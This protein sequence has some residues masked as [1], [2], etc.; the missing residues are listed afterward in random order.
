MEMIF[1]GGLP[2]LTKTDLSVPRL[3]QG[4]ESVCNASECF[5]CPEFETRQFAVSL[6][7][8][9]AKRDI[10]TAVVIKGLPCAQAIALEIDVSAR[11]IELRKTD[12]V[13][14]VPIE[15]MSPGQNRIVE[16][17]LQS[18]NK[19]ISR[20]QVSFSREPLRRLPNIKKMDG[21]SSDE[22]LPLEI[23]HSVNRP[24]RS[25]P[26]D[27]FQCRCK[28][29]RSQLLC[30]DLTLLHLDCSLPALP[31]RQSRR[32][33]HENSVFLV[34]SLGHL[35]LQRVVHV[36]KPSRAIGKLRT[37]QYLQLS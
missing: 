14:F 4:T 12:V 34:R 37:Q 29:C 7:I 1:L 33:L 21:S 20:G 28:L 27:T 19:F 17:G 36:N 24:H 31:G 8:E 16:M 18:L 25:L 2:K 3:V 9:L 35:G 30:T 5:F 32:I 23:Q 11:L 10:P 15:N 26:P 13:A 6:R 22:P